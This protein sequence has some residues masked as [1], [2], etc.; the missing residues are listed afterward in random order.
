M[1][2][3]SLT[4]VLGFEA[5]GAI[6][7]LKTLTNA[8][9]RYNIAL[10]ESIQVTEGYNRAAKGVDAQ[11]K[12]QA[13]ATKQVGRAQNKMA[14][15]AQKGSQALKGLEHQARTVGDTT[16][17]LAEKTQKA[18]KQMILSWQSVIRIFT[19][20]VIHRAVTRV[21]NALFSTVAA[22]RKFEISISEVET[23]ADTVGLSFDAL[24][25]Q[26]RQAAIAIG[27]PLDVVV[28][29]QYQL[30][31]NQVGNATESLI[32]FEASQRLALV[33]VTPLNSAVALITG[34]LNAYGAAVGG[35]DV[36]SAKL[37]KTV[38]LGRVRISEMG[39]SLGRV[40][41][42]ASQLGIS[43]D[44]VLASIATLTI[45]GVKA[46]D[47]MTQIL[48]VQLKLI[49]PTDAL[50]EA[51]ASLGFASAEAGIQAFGYQGFLQ[52]LR[53]TTD[54]TASSVGELFGRVR[55]TRGVMGKTG[56]AAE[57]YA[58]NLEAIKNATSDLLDEKLSLIFE[59]NA[60][61]VEIEL[62]KLNIAVT[63]S[64]GRGI[65]V[66]I[67]ETF[68]IFGG[69]VA[70]IATLATA[71]TAAG[72]AFL[73][74]RSGILSTLPALFAYQT[75]TIS[76]TGH[77]IR[78]KQAN[79]LASLSIK[80]LATATLAFLATPLGAAIAA[81]A[82]VTAIAIA[83]NKATAALEDYSEKVIAL[84][85]LILKDTLKKNAR[86]FADTKEILDKE[87]S[88]IQKKLAV[89][90]KLELEAAN[91]AKLIE[92]AL[93][94]SITD[95]LQARV[96][97]VQKFADAASSIVDDLNSK[98][99]DLRDDSR[100]IKDTIASFRFERKTK[101]MDDIEKFYANIRKSQEL[102]SK[103]Q[104]A[105]RRGEKELSVELNTQAGQYA[106]QA[107][108][109]ADASKNAAAVRKAEENKVD[110]LNDQLTTNRLI[111]R[112][113]QVRAARAAQTSGGLF[114]QA[115]EL[116]KLVDEYEQLGGKLSNVKLSDDD[117]KK[118][119]SEQIALAGKIES[120]TA[121]LA[122]RAPEAK[123]LGLEQQ[124]EDVIKSIREPLTGVE[125]DLTSAI[126]FDA[127]RVAR[128]LQVTLDAAGKKVR[129]T[130]I[131]L[132]GLQPG[133]AGITV[134]QELTKATEQ[135]TEYEQRL[136]GAVT[137]Q[138]ELN[139]LWSETSD[140]IKLT[141]KGLLETEELETKAL[142]FADRLGISEGIL[143]RPA[144]LAA[145]DIGE[146][147]NIKAIKDVTEATTKLIQEGG[148]LDEINANIAILA[149]INLEATNK[150]ML[151]VAVSLKALI[152]KLEDG[153]EAMLQIQ[154]ANEIDLTPIQERIKAIGEEMGGANDQANALI[155]TLNRLQQQQ[156]AVQPQGRSMG[157]LIHR[158][159]GGFIP[160]GTDTVPAMLSPG[161]FVVNAKS[162]SKFA[163]QLVAMNSG[164]QPI[165]RERGGPVT[166]VGDISIT[167]PGSATPPQTARAIMSAFRRE[168][169]RRT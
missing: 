40:T 116:K 67:K 55:A 160:K 26:A 140:L 21:S 155:S 74:M 138:G 19:I 121:Q 39:D 111:S 50:K 14:T 18:S 125:M 16:E 59:T 57:K 79:I 92:E 32:A 93:H 114:A 107:L 29:A 12:K 36:L 69:S 135:A 167:V 45:Q 105:I 2:E 86:R 1:A 117:R 126:I 169:R 30:L 51:M 61:Q 88:E 23:I 62:N 164:T 145:R 139:N 24:A 46:S 127:T 166:N 7:T 122:K 65:N 22:A 95:Q 148:N 94:E 131:Q 80:K 150:D 100:T 54:G 91:K 8:I 4:T 98:L 20:Q 15:Q 110:T 143:G 123:A 47:A 37:F 60:K 113:E 6:A 118:N 115:V 85:D 163:S 53:D 3:E 42:L 76:A 156:T 83:Y 120:K 27:Q 9:T 64:F 52:V 158:Q 49:R 11:F 58:K 75:T 142:R 154:E 147:V 90:V 96:S 119:M 56:A 99:K 17:R 161:E 128:T 165:Y 66:V 31:S 68:D 72:A 144:R 87:L 112:Q 108:A 149:S 97:A 78:F 157:G 106:D 35:A 152:T 102:R 70:T 77:I 134:A 133:A 13:E 10:I 137:A 43:I 129:L 71:A 63:E 84:N 48:N 146:D 104:A 124:F 33:G 25:D 38:E 153:K 34:T 168:T 151:G 81:A 159:F 101:G 82:A 132:A 103:A 130:G 5:A 141:T 41:V 28:E 109:S 162:A 73:I 89:Q 136:I 44:E